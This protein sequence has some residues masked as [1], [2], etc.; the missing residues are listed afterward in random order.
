MN[1]VQ[2]L[3]RLDSDEIVMQQYF[4]HFSRRCTALVSLFVSNHQ[5]SL[6]ISFGKIVLDRDQRDIFI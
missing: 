4:H 1:D 3:N 6:L 2:K 5:T